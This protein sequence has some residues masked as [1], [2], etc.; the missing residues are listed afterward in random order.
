VAFILTHHVNCPEFKGNCNSKIAKQ[1]LHLK[2]DLHLFFVKNC[3]ALFEF[4]N[5]F[6]QKHLIPK[7]QQK[8]RFYAFDIFLF[9]IKL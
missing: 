2:I 6:L 3:P 9:T 5:D 1:N 8:S 4:Q 7:K